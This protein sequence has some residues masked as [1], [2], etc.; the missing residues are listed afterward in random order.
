[1]LALAIYQEA[2]AHEAQLDGCYVIKTDV[3]GKTATAATIHQRHKDLAKVERAFRTFNSGHLE[4]RHRQDELHRE[5]KAEIHQ[6]RA[7]LNR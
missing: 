3:P 1:M 7:E 5:L 6:L 2:W 4:I